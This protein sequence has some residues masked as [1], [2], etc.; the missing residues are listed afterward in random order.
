[1]FFNYFSLKDFCIINKFAKLFIMTTFR[2]SALERAYSHL[3]LS[4][5]PDFKKPSEIFG[6]NVFGKEAMRQY[7]PADSFKA[8]ID[9]I[10]LGGKIDSKT[11]SGVAAGMKAWSLSKGATHYTHWFQPFSRATGEKHDSFLHPAENMS[12]I[13]KFEAEQLIQQEPDAS[14]FPSGGMRSTFEARGYTAWDPS[15]PAFIMGSTLCIPTIFISYTGEALDYKTPLLKAL[16]LINKAAV[17]ICQYFDKKIKKVH[18]TLGWEQEYFLI[19]EALFNAR[20]DLVLSGRTVFGH[21]PAK[22]QQL[23]DH[24]FGYIPE[25][26]TAFM[27]DFEFES[28]KLG[29]PVKTRHNEVAPNQFELAPVFEEVNLSNDHNQLV[30][31]VMDKTARKH[32]FRVLF[33]EKPFEGINGSGKHNNWSLMTNTGKNL[34]N[35]GKTPETNLMFLSFF[36]NIIKAVHDY[37]DLLRATIATAN[38]DHRLG[39]NE[40]PPAIISAFVGTQLYKVL[41]EIETKIKD[42]NQ[43]VSA[44][45]L[46]LDKIPEI[47]FDET[48]RNRT[49]PFAFT[50]NKF[51]FRA[52]GSSANCSNP[53]MI[54]STIVA[55]Q[56]IEFKSDVDALI[57]SGK[58]KEEAILKV[59]R[60]YIISSKNILFEGDNYS[61]KWVV[62]AAKRGLPNI[63]NTPEALKAYVSDKNHRLFIKYKILTIRELNARYHIELENYYKTIQIESR[64]IGDIAL[65]HIIPTAIHYQNTLIENVKGIKTIFKEQEA[66][67]LTAVQIETISDISKHV[68][69]IKTK[70][71]QMTEER[72]KANKIK[73]ISKHARQYCDKVKPYFD[74]IR[75]HV[76]K[77]ELLIDDENWTLPKY[78]ELLYIR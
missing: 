12:S 13:E 62:E 56:L 17:D 75:Y 15:S 76:D 10:E 50:G 40:A 23:E 63:Q 2:K 28:W 51:E 26:V 30:M 70:V 35:P 39:A 18:G 20:P 61:D 6:S 31:H 64:I 65:N 37:S 49:S 38:N 41:N 21:S 5:I 47:S 34:L 36:V 45:K 53:M 7:I 72:S 68:S 25:R 46:F 54:L 78:R 32:N 16:S 60:N 3:P 59:I 55:N 1:M 57:N 29:I 8:I 9:V 52:P 44:Y 74:E 14:S 77:L 43:K 48:D 42:D 67:M 58:Q 4:V 19:D 24:Y 71:H 69:V 22:G 11:A 73:D 66:N 27:R 33:H